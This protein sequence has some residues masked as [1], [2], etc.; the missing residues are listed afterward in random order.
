MLP[1]AFLVGGGSGVG[2]SER[3]ALEHE[4]GKGLEAVVVRFLVRDLTLDHV[5]PEIPELEPVL[6][7][8]LHFQQV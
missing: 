3:L 8:L 5:L 6:P 2:E 1:A 7:V 4:R